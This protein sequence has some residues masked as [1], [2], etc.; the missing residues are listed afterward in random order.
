MFKNGIERLVS[1]A[2]VLAMIVSIFGISSFVSQNAYGSG[3][4]TG[5][6]DPSVFGETTEGL[7]ST[8][9]VLVDSSTGSYVPGSTVYFYISTAP[10]PSGIVGEYV[11]SYLIP[12]DS[13]SLS[14]AIL[15]LFSSPTSLSPGI[16]YILSATSDNPAASGATF[17]DAFE[18]DVVSTQPTF[19]LQY[20]IGILPSQQNSTITAPVSASVGF[21]GSG[22]DPGAT[23]YIT[24]DYAGG[25]NLLTYWSPG[26]VDVSQYGTIRQGLLW[27]IGVPYLSGTVS[28]SGS[29]LAKPYVI[30]AQEV[31]GV[32]NIV[33]ITADAYLNVL[34]SI[35]PTS[36]SGY[37]GSTFTIT[38]TGFLA[39]QTIPAFPLGSTGTSPIQVQSGNV[40]L[41]A[42]YSSGGTAD[43][44][45]DL[46]IS[47]V[48][49]TSPVAS[50]FSVDGQELLITFSDPSFTET[51][52]EVLYVS[53]PG[54][55][56]SLYVSPNEGTL[57]DK[58]YCAVT[59][60]SPSSPIKLY[61]GDT[62]EDLSTDS[63]GFA[64]TIAEVASV[65]EGDYTLIASDSSFSATASF[66]VTGTSVEILDSDYLNLSGEYASLG[67]YIIVGIGGLPAYSPVNIT[68]T[69]LATS[70]FG[71]S[72]VFAAASEK[73][74][75]L[76]VSISAGYENAKGFISNG[77][78]EFLIEYPLTYS[79]SVNTG[80]AFT[81]SISSAISG[82]ATYY[83]V[84]T[85]SV[86]FN[87]TS[88]FPAS[89]VTIFIS[90]LVPAGASHT[91]ET[92]NYIGP[93]SIALDSV[94]PVTLSGDRTTF[95]STSSG[96]ATVSF[97]LPTSTDGAHTLVIHSSRG[98]SL[99]TDYNL[100]VS[101]P[102][103][104]GTITYNTEKPTLLLSGTGTST[105]PFEGYPA[106]TSSDNEGYGIEF[107]FFNLQ[108]NSP[109]S[110]V[111]YGS[112][113]TSAVSLPASAPIDSNGAGTVFIPFPAAI[114][115]VE[116]EI[117]FAQVRGSIITTLSGS[118]WYYEDVPAIS[119]EPSSFSS[120]SG[121]PATDYLSYYGERALADTNVTIYANSLSPD[122]EYDIYMSTST[123]FSASQFV[124]SFK[125][126]GGGDTLTGA[127]VPLSVGIGTYTIDIAPST[128]SMSGKA[129]LTLTLE[130]AVDEFAFPG[131][132]VSTSIPVSSSLAT[133]T[134]YYQV[135]VMLNETTLTTVDTPPVG[136]PVSSPTEYYANVTFKM[137]NGQP[138][139]WFLISYEVVPVGTSTSATTIQALASS[140]TITSVSSFTIATPNTPVTQTVVV[141]GTVSSAA[142][143]IAVIG[144]GFTVSSGAEVTNVT[145][146]G[147]SLSGTTV[148][149]YF[150]V[151]VN[152]A[153]PTTYTLTADQLAYSESST[154]V[155]P[156][157]GTSVSNS[158]GIATLVSN[159]G[160]LLMGISPSQIATLTA[161]VTSAVT[162]SMQVPLSELNASVVSINVSINNAVATIKTAFG[163]MTATL[164][165]INATVAGISSGQV[166]V[167]T[168]LGSIETSL[169]SLNASLAAFNGNI[170]TIN[171]TLGQVKTTLA[172]INTQVTTNG[173]GIAT[174]QTDLGTLGGYVT[175]TN[176]NVS[177]IKTN[178]GTLTTTVGKIQTG[179][180]QVKSYTSTMS[181]LIILVIALVILVAVTLVISILEL[182][183]N[184]KVPEK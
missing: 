166:L 155:V 7:L 83:A 15:E 76:S 23:V 98:Q 52:S 2:I 115:G 160:A 173:N 82:S 119:F 114:G 174:I 57:L 146:G 44:S 134:S 90:G 1:I 158:L 53:I 39:G 161:D 80:R 70:S 5:T 177:T 72:S 167:L 54:V 113:G 28:S 20:P 99:Y 142:D 63:N 51:F 32:G 21:Y 56:P 77:L 55:D 137:P 105:N 62:S 78:G 181:T 84:G 64:R 163:N 25:E 33:G 96:T 14:G 12:A 130:V 164:S 156:Y 129:V 159:N 48:T 179:V 71:T 3:T 22:W 37:A 118:T 139:N 182:S 50:T 123:S 31:S 120:N 61:F 38:G 49:V 184:K 175:A 127:T 183:A 145:L 92:S 85:P 6:L 111:I 135:A 81:I 178:L 58:F 73:H 116:F 69:G 170:V 94:N 87:S 180:N 59:G 100:L 40:Y 128:Q 91:P 147:W 101:S 122:T 124:S 172:G 9:T 88:Y 109:V 125:T 150:E 8:T 17:P 149:A 157:Y 112:T 18:I 24:L 13:T 151:T 67:S 108:P 103:T 117:A 19:F 41:N 153:T 168:K 46:S 86:T 121:H 95:N 42:Y 97:N 132:L 106:L 136:L 131:Q 16:Y 75:P 176:G 47:G 11:G 4:V 126:D 104:S 27:S 140:P 26:Y 74:S 10:D 169:A 34:P 102:S 29:F 35:S 107:D 143:L 30:V 141:T 133:G 110:I 36:I 165:A 45:G 144:G 93:F 66:T 152:S 68:D 89:A 43:S 154:V 60:F 148:T 171:T 65:Q 162:T 79:V 138:G